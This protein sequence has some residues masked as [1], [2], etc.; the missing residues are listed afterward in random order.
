MSYKP[1]KDLCHYKAIKLDS[2]FIE[3]SN[4]KRSNITTIYIYRHPNIDLDEF[5]NNYLN[6]LLDK[7]SKENKSFFLLVHFN[8]DLLK[9]NKHTPT[10]K[11]LYSLFPLC[12]YPILSNQLESVLLSKPLLIIFFSDNNFIL[13]YLVVDWPDIIKS[14]K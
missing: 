1:R 14:E 6:I 12:F 7:L 9:Y 13:D 8:V 11:F 10:N 4:P 2:S 5:S 3:I